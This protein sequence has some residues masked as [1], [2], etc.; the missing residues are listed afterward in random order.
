M[1]R[2]NY[3]KVVVE[4][5]YGI[6]LCSFCNLNFYLVA[7]PVIIAT[8]EK[9]AMYWASHIYQCL[10]PEPKLELIKYLQRSA[11]ALCKFQQDLDRSFQTYFGST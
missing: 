4:K 1:Q 10:G 3:N 9:W 7:L 11:L 5:F 6:I 8:F 2:L